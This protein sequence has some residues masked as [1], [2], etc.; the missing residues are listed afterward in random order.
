MP[1]KTRARST[2]A[3][4][5][6]IAVVVI[7]VGIGFLMPHG[8]RSEGE[9]AGAASASAAAVKSSDQVASQTQSSTQ[10]EEAAQGQSSEES[11][12]ATQADQSQE[13]AQ[14]DQSQ[15]AASTASDTSNLSGRDAELALD[16]NRTDWNMEQSNEKVVYLTIDDGPSKNTQ[17]VLDILD[18]YGCKATF[19]VVGHDPDYYHLIG[20]AYKRGHTIG[21]H[22]MTH[23]YAQVYSSTSAF[24]DD[25]D[26]IGQV[27]KDQIGY[28]PCFIRFP[29][30]SSNT[31]SANYTSG[32]MSDLVSLVQQRGYQYFDW[33]LSC[34]DGSDLT[35]EELIAESCIQPE[36]NNIVFLC[37]DSAAKD[38]TV[39]ALP[40]IIE[41]FQRLGY[42]FK[43]LDRN[44]WVCHHGVN[45]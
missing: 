29:G 26:Q 3:I 41:H 35:T 10:S 28:V 30:G 11:A 23:D 15:D 25:L 2:G 31:I 12:D 32:I 13:A 20:E 6:V 40:T 36:S 16:P 38:T 17:A 39:A 4:V 24:F 19:F 22:S 8:T 9:S 14:S 1:K 33:N 37:H 43:A 34:G 42:T 27:V 21:L 5:A 18:R 7:A 45:N 44:S